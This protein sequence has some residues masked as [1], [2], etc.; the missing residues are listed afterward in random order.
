MAPGSASSQRD[1]PFASPRTKP[2]GEVPVKQPSDDWLCSKMEKFNITLTEGYS[3]CGSETLM[4][5]SAIF[6]DLEHL[7]HL[8]KIT[9]G[10][11]FIFKIIYLG[12]YVAFNTVQFISRWVVFGRA[13][14]TSTYSLLGFC[15]VKCRPTASNYQLS[16]LRP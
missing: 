6:Q 16:H 3:I 12:F 15:T 9:Y 2:T 10:G 5:L 14:E 7:Y 11:H 4:K 13:E 8:Q 1:N